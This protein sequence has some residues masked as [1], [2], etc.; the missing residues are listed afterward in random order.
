MEF[1]TSQAFLEDAYYF[2]DG[3]EVKISGFQSPPP[4]AYDYELRDAPYDD[5][6][7]LYFADGSFTRFVLER[8]VIAHQPGYILPTVEIFSKQG[9]AGS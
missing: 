2:F 5:R 1:R 9:V 4:P 6:W 3:Q 7:T 8:I